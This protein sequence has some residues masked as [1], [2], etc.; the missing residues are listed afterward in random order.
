M[1]RQSRQ[2]RRAQERRQAQRR[3]SGTHRLDHG[4]GVQRWQVLTGVGI[5]LLAL[6]IFADAAA[7]GPPFGASAT[8]TPQETP[9]KTIA[10]LGCDPMEQNH[11]HIH[12]AIRIYDHGK[13]LKPSSDIGHN[14]DHDCLYWLHVHSDNGVIH[15]ESP[16]VIHPTLGSF[17][18]VARYTAPG[19][20]WDHL[21][22]SPRPAMKVWVNGKPYAGNPMNIPLHQHTDIQV[23]FGPP[24]PPYKP[25]NFAANGV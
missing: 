8:A 7:G 20:S 2:A 16:K 9:G 21:S 13:L 22:F 15:L 5:I 3:A 4:A 25:F 11:F 18:A 24:F 12:Q 6:L 1:G 10:G 17:F 23:D 19:T 14:Y